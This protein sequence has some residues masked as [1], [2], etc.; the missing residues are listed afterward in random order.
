MK[1]LYD[2][3]MKTRTLILCLFLSALCSCKHTQ[4]S[5]QPQKTEIQ[6]R[7]I[8]FKKHCDNFPKSKAHVQ[9]ITDHC[10]NISEE[11]RSKPG[12]DPMIYGQYLTAK[13]FE[14]HYIKLFSMVNMRYDKKT[15]DKLKDQFKKLRWLVIEDI[16]QDINNIRG[17]SNM[18][19]L[20]SSTSYTHMV[21]NILSDLIYRIHFEHN[22]EYI[23]GNL[24]EALEYLDNFTP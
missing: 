24:S 21:E 14:D 22:P 20:S 10:W 15:E 2:W 19:V 1:I 17:I 23:D 16:Y 12:L 5:V 9:K 3:S 11:L 13:C 8:S 18:S 4:K 6:N 7:D